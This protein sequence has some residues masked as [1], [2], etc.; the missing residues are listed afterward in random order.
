M[1]K[2]YYFLG[3]LVS[4]SK[5]P[6][7]QLCLSAISAQ[8]VTDSSPAFPSSHSAKLLAVP[9]LSI[10]SAYTPGQGFSDA[11]VVKNP[12]AKQEMQER[13]VPFWIRKVPWSRKWQPTLE[14]LPGIIPWIEEHGGLLPIGSQR[15]RHN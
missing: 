3:I 1:N 7:G 4:L 8:N 12:P 9:A 14:F 2:Y 5:G 6:Q 10:T 15:V 13:Q 11:S